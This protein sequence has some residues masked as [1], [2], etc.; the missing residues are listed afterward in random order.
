MSN[1]SA[2]N[3]ATYILNSAYPELPNSVVFPGVLVAGT[4][5][6]SDTRY[7]YYNTTDN[8]PYYYS[9]V[10][11]TWVEFTGST[12]TTPLYVMLSSNFTAGATNATGLVI[13][14]VT[15]AYYTVGM[16][17]TVLDNT[18]TYCVYQCT[19]IDT[20]ANQLT[21]TRVDQNEVASTYVFSTS[22]GAYITSGG[23]GSGSGG[24]STSLT[25]DPYSV[26]VADIPA[27]SWG[28]GS[29]YIANF[30]DISSILASDNC[31]VRCYVNESCM[32]ADANRAI[33][34][35]PLPSSGIV[36]GDIYCGA[37]ISVP[38]SFG[39]FVSENLYLN[40]YNYQNFTESIT[41]TFTSSNA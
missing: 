12:A 22:N 29:L 3:L 20:L 6:P 21:L 30:G 2:D 10:S 41:L 15:V 8:T 27:S 25:V 14:I 28:T 38:I 1:N 13:S 4:S 5:P 16:F 31:L 36:S 17:F 26:T 7:L 39:D 32:L 37:G 18:L 11:S 23:A 9:L 24:G 33:G 34:T 40:V 19:T 35:A